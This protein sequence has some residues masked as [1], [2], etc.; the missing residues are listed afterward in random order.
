M[1]LFL[2]EILIFWAKFLNIAFN[3]SRRCDRDRGC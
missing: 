1:A 3:F 2:E